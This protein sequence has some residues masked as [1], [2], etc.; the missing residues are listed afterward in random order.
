MHAL[1][2]KNKTKQKQR[3]DPVTKRDTIFMRC[4]PQVFLQKNH[5]TK[6]LIYTKFTQCKFGAKKCKLRLNKGQRW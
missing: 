3:Y 2:T 1:K 6:N 5:C 4:V